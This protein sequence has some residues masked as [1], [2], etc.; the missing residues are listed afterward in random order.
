MDTLDGPSDEL[1]L[2]IFL[3]VVLNRFHATIFSIP[4]FI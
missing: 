3:V 2:G 1:D 4:H